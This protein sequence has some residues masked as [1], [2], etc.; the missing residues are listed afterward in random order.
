MERRITLEYFSPPMRDRNN[1]I[2]IFYGWDGWL[3]GF[4]FSHYQET[5]GL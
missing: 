3:G 4:E 5:L 2:V 1:R